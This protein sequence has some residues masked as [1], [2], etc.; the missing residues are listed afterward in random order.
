VLAG[1]LEHR[2][3]AGHEGVITPG[4]AQRMSAGRGVVHSEMNHSQS[5]PVHFV[6]MW[7]VPDTTGVEPSYEQVNV[8]SR[9]DA[10][11]LVTVA[12][13]R[14]VD[15]GVAI[16]QEDA[17]FSVGW[18]TDG[19]EVEVPDAPFVHVFVAKGQA[20]LADDELDTGD[21][22][23]LTGAGGLSLVARGPAEVLVWASR[24]SVTR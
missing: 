4:V 10:G 20:A 14:E 8:S 9:L 22:A 6:Q 2:D 12:A 7:V 11:G 23:R 15:G 19:E 24:G 18:L 21:A 1:A 13:G 5:E 16:H 3:S 17:A